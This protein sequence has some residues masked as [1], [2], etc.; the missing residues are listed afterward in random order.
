MKRIY[1]P[2]LTL[3]LLAGCPEAPTP[4]TGYLLSFM[5]KEAGSAF[6]PTRLIVNDKFV[7]IDAGADS[8][9]FILLDRA[10]R[11]IYS[12]TRRDG[13]ILVIAPQLVTLA[14]PQ[15]FEHR[16]EKLP[17]DDAPAVG[18]RPVTRYRLFTNDAMC[19]EIFAAA[20][21]L[22]EPRKALGE[23]NTVLAGEQAAALRLVPGEQQSACDLANNVFLPNRQIE[24]GFPIRQ[25]DMNGRVRELV[26][27]QEN[28]TPDPKLFE[29]PASFRRYTP[30][31]M[32]AGV[33]T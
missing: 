19:Y 33:K 26:N 25:Q 24:F 14:A 31:D 12:V 2:A 9:D 17:S 4:K 30:Q 23:F 11:T 18:G 32:I 5:E 20:G 7:R 15:K 21:L 27:F 13:T 28:Y 1:L 22:E 29:L 8:D 6:S 16:I 3:L 10:A